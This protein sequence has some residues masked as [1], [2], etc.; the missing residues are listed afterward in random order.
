MNVQYYLKQLKAGTTAWLAQSVER[1]TLSTSVLKSYGRGFEP[2]IGLTSLFW[3][4]FFVD[5]VTSL[6]TSSLSLAAW[7]RV[8]ALFSLQGRDIAVRTAMKHV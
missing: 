1:T 6:P 2:R 4:L 3:P 8:A 7:P 5:D